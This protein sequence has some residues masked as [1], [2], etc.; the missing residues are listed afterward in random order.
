MGGARHRLC[1]LLLLGFACAWAG[2]LQAQTVAEQYL[3]N[4]ANQERAERGLGPLRWD[5]QLANA[6][7]AHADE[8]SERASISHQF[9]GEPELTRR[10]AAAGVK[11]SMVAENVAEAP[12]PL[13]M[14][15]A[16][17]H[18]EGHRANLLAPAAD[19]VGIAVVERSGEL[20]AVQDFAHVTRSLTYGQQ[21]DAVRRLVDQAAPVGWV[22]DPFYARST[23]EMDTGY[24]GPRPGYVMRFT[25][26]DLTALPIDLVAKLRSGGY[27]QAAV[28]ACPAETSSIFSVYAVAVLLY[29]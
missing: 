29:P 14:H 9:A 18:S 15:D 23:C 28:G 5:A 20:Y 22:D 17:M 6:A 24:V 19:A 8:M 16:W 13:R 2:A 11:F 7:R 25:A 10:A 12:S 1:W 3:F 27:R 26:N 4:A 21:E